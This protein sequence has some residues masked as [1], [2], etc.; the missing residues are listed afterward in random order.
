MIISFETWK[1]D[2]DYWVGQLCGLDCDSLPDCP[3]R[4][5]YEARVS[6]KTAARRAV[7]MAR[8]W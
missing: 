2:V 1:R 7:Q 5:W 4:L 3:Y 8:E 6:A